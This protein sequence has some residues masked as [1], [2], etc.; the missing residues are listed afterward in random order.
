[1]YTRYDDF[2]IFIKLRSE[3]RVLYDSRSLNL[4]VKFVNKFLH[5][6]LYWPVFQNKTKI[7]KSQL[8]I[9]LLSQKWYC[10]TIKCKKI[11]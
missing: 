8:G 3:N 1:M 11:C 4:G 5:Q 2:S 10:K 7:T 6:K 9:K